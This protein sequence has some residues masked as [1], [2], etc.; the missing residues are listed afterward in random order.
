[1]RHQRGSWDGP[2]QKVALLR[3]IRLTAAAAT[4]CALCWLPAVAQNQESD[5][6]VLRAVG[7][8]VSPQ[9]VEFLA[10]NAQAA[11]LP[12]TGFS[13]AESTP[14][15]NIIQKLC[16]MVSP[17][18]VK[19]AA[20][21]NDL[22]KLDLDTPLGSRVRSIRWPP[23]L[24]AA[25]FPQSSPST[26]TVQRGD[27]AYD[28][29]KRLTGGDGSR[30]AME[31]FFGE[32]FSQLVDLKPGRVLRIAAVTQPVAF[33]PIGLSAHEFTSSALAMDRGAAMVKNPEPALGDIVMGVP[34]DGVIAS[35][36]TCKPLT[37]P[38][39]NPIHVQK[40]YEFAS[41][42]GATRD[43]VY[44]GK[45]DIV[46]VDNGFFGAKVMDDGSDAFVGSTFK[47]QWFKS[48][49]AAGIASAIPSDPPLLP[50]NHSHQIPVTMTSG[51]GT[52]VTGLALG[53]PSFL[54]YRESLGKKAWAQVTV[55]NVGRGQRTLVRGTPGYLRGILMSPLPRIVNFSIAHDR[56]ARD[57]YL[58][59]LE[60]APQSLF[61]AAAGNTD[62]D[63]MLTGAYP[64]A[65]GGPGRTNVIT[66]AALEGKDVLARSSGRAIAAVDM[67]APG[68][69]LLSWIDN[70]A[71]KY[72]MSGTSQAAPL[73]TFA[74]SLLRSQN[75]RATPMALK[76]RVIVSGDML[77]TDDQSR[78]AFA[79]KLNIAK[80]LLWFD[81]FIEVEGKEKGRYLGRL[82]RMDALQC[83]SGEV[84]EVLSSS[85]MW[86]AKRDSRDKL[87]YFGGYDQNRLARPCVASA[88]PTATL[89]FRVTHRIREDGSVVDEVGR[90]IDASVAELKDFVRRAQF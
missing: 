59:I 74:A 10:R 79:V 68:C 66:V 61:V 60:N 49:P 12:Q 63:P 64:A 33:V 22:D 67:A 7:P 30:P 45:V 69:Q 16:G 44:P 80:A 40:A 58:E 21:I 85:D 88:D 36:F 24:F 65:L 46:V 18:Y 57:T 6:G 32:P 47:Q 70:T 39:F 54:E 14:A 50:I 20:E 17:A 52:H 35:G 62:R 48:D 53:G 71:N 83:V 11:P 37:S 75:T 51:H 81:D 13:T 56:T 55:L 78:T 76:A 31:R 84:K 4:A 34:M 86:A 89:S 42:R 8:H 25:A 73:V 3:G 87:H 15:R 28:I 27:T 29:Y 1:M 26:V 41:E 9:I 38:P 77:E 90:D 5:R 2:V 23:C 43:D 72:E 82:N 19:V